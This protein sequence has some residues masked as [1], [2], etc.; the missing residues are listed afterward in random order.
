[1]EGDIVLIGGL[2]MVMGNLP[3]AV[4]TLHI[5]GAE[6]LPKIR[7]DDECSVGPEIAEFD[8]SVVGVP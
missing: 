8:L 4:A 6:A 3:D 2:E 5:A 7:I 1:L